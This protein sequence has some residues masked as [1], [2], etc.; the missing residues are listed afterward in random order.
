MRKIY[1]IKEFGVF[2]QY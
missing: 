2:L 1:A